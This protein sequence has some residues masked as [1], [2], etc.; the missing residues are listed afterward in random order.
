[1]TWQKRF[2]KGRQFLDGLTMFVFSLGLFVLFVIG[3]V[4]LIRIIM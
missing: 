4:K 2:N 3:L 1:M